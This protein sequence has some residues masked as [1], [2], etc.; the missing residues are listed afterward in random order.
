MNHQSIALIKRVLDYNW[1]LSFDNKTVSVGDSATYIRISDAG[2]GFRVEI[3]QNGSTVA[4]WT[5]ARDLETIVSKPVKYYVD[6]VDWQPPAT[7]SLASPKK[8]QSR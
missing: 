5:D 2:I 4:D 7:D 6:L 3:A 1:S 8:R